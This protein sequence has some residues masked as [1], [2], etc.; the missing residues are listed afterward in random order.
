MGWMIWIHIE[1]ECVS[2]APLSTA[3]IQPHVDSSFTETKMKPP[4]MMNSSFISMAVILTMWTLVCLI[5]TARSTKQTQEKAYSGDLENEDFMKTKKM[6]EPTYSD[7][8]KNEDWDCDGFM[9]T[10]QSEEKNSSGD[11]SKEESKCEKFGNEEEIS[12]DELG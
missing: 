7:D 11:Q 6:E 9:K 12:D 2:C 10:K 1:W 5:V 8:Q 3:D 4:F